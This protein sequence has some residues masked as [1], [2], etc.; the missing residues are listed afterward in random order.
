MGRVSLA[1]NTLTRIIGNVPIIDHSVS[2]IL[3][4]GA[5]IFMLHRVLPRDHAS[6]DP[7][8]VTST[9]VLADFLDW[10]SEHFQVRPLDEVALRAETLHGGSP[11]CA[12]T[13]DDGWLDNYLYAFPA[14]KERALPA[15]IFLPVSFI[16]TNRRFWPELL[17]S[18]LEKLK[19]IAQRREILA[20]A[21]R[22]FP[23]SPPVAAR[24]SDVD[25]RRLLMTRSSQEAEE[26]VHH[27]AELIGLSEV[28]RDRAWLNWDEVRKMEDAGISF[29]SHTMN[30]ALLTG[31][32]P[33]EAVSE[34]RRSREEL[35]ERLGH[36]VL[37][38]AYPWGRASLV[39]REAVRDAGYRFALT[40]RPGLVKKGTDPWL[41]PRL[42]A[43]NSVLCRTFSD[44]F[45][46]KG[47][48]LSLTRSMLFPRS[49]NSSTAAGKANPRRIKIVFVIDQITEW[50]GGT[51]RQLQALIQGLDLNYF[52]PEL[53]F[54]FPVDKLPRETLPCPT[55]WVCS[56]QTRIPSF[57]VRLF[58]LMKL[59]RKIRPQI[60][61]TFFIE[62]IFAGILGSWLI[63]V[64]QIVGSARN[65]GH[66]KK[67]RHRIAFRSVARLA[68][69]WQCNSRALWDYVRKDEGVR[70]SRIEILP[71]AIDLCRFRPPSQ[72]ERLAMR[73]QLRLSGEGPFVVSV[74]NLAPIKDLPL[75]LD[76][77]NLLQSDLRNAIYLFVGEGPLRAALQL[78]AEQL[79]LA[80]AVRFVGRQA[81]VRPYL[82]AADFGVITS[83]S[84]GSSNS[85]LE[86]MAMGLPSVVTEIPA[87]R[88]LVNGLFFT[89]GDA[90]GLSQQLLMLWRD[91]TLCSRL[92]A[93][94]A[95]TALEFSLQKFIRRTQGFYTKLAAQAL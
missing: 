81:D 4:S 16:G 56:D 39:T 10:L 43:G 48:K 89:P 92:R 6:Y 88:E 54:I 1:W 23:W 67:R 31:M 2:R 27:L 37:G 95:Q 34:I 30:H 91:A 76:A 69:H 21:T 28:R 49:A 68:H 51:E 93:Q 18:C 29:G 25:L 44:P 5:S 33:S 72:Q 86:Y 84:E 19:L 62:G 90:A 3:K 77:A 52:D 71:N 53:W 85:L 61:Q 9:D 13:F 57:P 8:L 82:A 50:E 73:H 42:A 80:Q 24:Q 70:P 7:G 35:T 11:P 15:S 59:L 41:L 45:H 65:A 55:R 60:V 17:W 58:R 87:N 40:T 66:W 38:F 79:G 64:P 20:E 12:I 32:P 46:A 63:R 74:A 75:L 22:R 14:L 78:R 36:E 83:R 94:Y 26:F 47:V